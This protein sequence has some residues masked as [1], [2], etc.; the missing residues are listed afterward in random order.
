M[1]TKRNAA[2]AVPQEQKVIGSHDPK[3]IVKKSGYQETF[4]SKDDAKKVYDDLKKTS[5]KNKE[6]I[7]ME[8]AEVDSAGSKKVVESVNINEGFYA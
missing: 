6:S 1:S 3:F 5:V 7:K 8:L 4:A 2:A